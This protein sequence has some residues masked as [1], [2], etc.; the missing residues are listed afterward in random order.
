MNTADEKRVQFTVKRGEGR[1]A[2]RALAFV[3]EYVVQRGAG[4]GGGDKYESRVELECPALLVWRQG[5]QRQRVI[6]LSKPLVLRAKLETA[7]AEG[8]ALA[9]AA[10]N[11]ADRL[12]ELAIENVFRQ[13]FLLR[14]TAYCIHSYTS[15]SILLYSSFKFTAL[16]YTNQ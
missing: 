12:A 6:G 3:A 9:D 5:Q 14:G 10:G 13:P 16:Q 1:A 15:I 11:R 4:A 8:G 7:G 2:E